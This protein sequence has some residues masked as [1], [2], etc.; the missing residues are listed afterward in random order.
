MK[1]PHGCPD[2]VYV[3][4]K[5]QVFLRLSKAAKTWLQKFEDLRIHNSFVAENKQFVSDSLIQILYKM[6]IY[7]HAP[8][9]GKGGGGRGRY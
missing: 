2:S 5:R 3:I 6:C 8:S 7:S 4:M 9:P 1:Q